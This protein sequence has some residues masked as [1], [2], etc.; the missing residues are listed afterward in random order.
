MSELDIVKEQIAYL[1]YWQGV[2]VVTDLALIGW[3]I[4]NIHGSAIALRVL[5]GIAVLA[6]TLGIYLLH[7]RI[8]RHIEALRNL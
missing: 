1:K 4:S 6:L 2:M 7:R 5:A 3:L 8:E